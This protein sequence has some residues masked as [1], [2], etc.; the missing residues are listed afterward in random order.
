M[1]ISKHILFL[2][3]GLQLA[4]MPVLVRAQTD[5][6]AGAG[7]V[8][9]GDSTLTDSANHKSLQTLLVDCSINGSPSVTFNTSATYTMS[10]H[11]LGGPVD[12]WGVSC[13]TVQSSSFTT[14]VVLFNS[15]GCSSAT[16]TAYSSGTAVATKTITITAPALGGGSINTPTPATVNYN[17]SPSQ[18]TTTGASGG[19]CSSYSYQ[20]QSSIVSS[21][22]GFSNVSGATSQDFQ[23]GPIT[24]TTWYRRQVSCGIQTA[25][26]SNVVE[27]DVY[28]AISG[29]SVT[30][31]QNINYGATPGVLSVTGYSGGDGSYSYQWQSATDAGF[32]SPTNVGTNSTSYQPPALTSSLYYRVVVTSNGAFAGSSAAFV[33]VYPLLIAGSISP[34]SQTINYNTAPATMTATAASGG[35]GTYTYQ[36]YYWPEGGSAWVLITGATSLSYSPGALTQTTS[37]L[38]QAWSNGAWANSDEVTV[39][40]YPQIVPGSISPSS[41]NANYNWTP[42]GLSISSASGGDGSY[43]YQWQSSADNSF[44][45]PSNVG[46]NS[47]SY[48]PAALTASAYYRVKVTSNGAI[49]PSASAFINVY[50]VVNPGTVSPASQSISYNTAPSVLSVTGVSGGDGSYSYQWQSSPDNSFG[51]PTNVGTNATSYQP[52][53]LTAFVYYRCLVTSNGAQATSVSGEVSIAL[54]GGTISGPSTILPYNGST[55]LNNV[56]GAEGGNCGGSY[57]YQWLQSQDGVHF[58]SISGATGLSYTTD[59]LTVSTVFLRQVVC[60]SDWINSNTILVTVSP[61]LNYIRTRDLTRPGIIDPAS[62]ASLTDPSDVKQVT[63]YFDGLGR[64]VQAVAKQ[65]SPGLKDMVTL[66]VYDALGREP[67]KYLPYVSS[68][69]DGNFR[70]DGIAEAAAFNSV[71]F[72]NEHVFYGQTNFEPSPLNRPVTTLAPGDSWVGAGRGVTLDYLVNTIADS[73]HY[74]TIAAAAGSLPSDAGLYAAGVLYKNQT[75]DEQGHR[76]VEYKDQ[77]GKVILKK[78]QADDTPGTAH[79]GWLCTYYVYD[80]MDNL[81]FVLPPKAIELVNG[82]GTWTVGQTIADELCFRYEYDYRKRMSIKKVPGAGE[83]HMVYDGRDRLVLTQDSALRSQQKWT[84]IRYDGQNRPDSTGLLTDPSNYNNQEHH[85]NLAGSSSSYPNVSS[86][87]NELLTRTFYD[88]YTWTP[89]VWS[90][91]TATMYSGNS[92]LFMTASN[93]TFPYPQPVTQSFNTR[94]MVTGGTKEIVGQP[95]SYLSSVNYFD[96]R[97]RLLQNISVNLTGCGEPATMQYSF[98]GQPLVKD[99]LAQN[100]SLA[101]NYHVLS[102]YNYDAGGRLLDIKKTILGGDGTVKKAQ[103]T[104]VSNTYNELGQLQKKNLGGLDSMVYDYNIRGWL[105]GINKN[106][107]GGTE[108]HYFGMDLGYDKSTSIAGTTSY[109]TPAFNGNISGTVWKSAGDGINRKYDFTYDNVNRLTGA[110]FLQNPSG[111]TWNTTAMDYSVSNLHYDANGN[112]LSMNQNGFKIGAPA[113][114]IDQLTYSYQTSSN[115][116]IQVND[117]VNDTASKLGDFHYKGSKGS[118]DYSYDGNGNLTLDNNKGI[119]QISYNYLN[120]PQ[121]VH[122]NGKGNIIYTYDAAGNKL[123]KVVMDSVSGLA[124]TTEYLGAFQYQR[125]A[126]I[127]SPTAGT[128]TLQFMEEEEGRARWAFHRYLNGTTGYGWEY[129]FT[130]K[131]HLGNT[132]VLLTQEKDTAQ[133]V[134]TMEAAYRSTELALF[135]NIDSTSY[136]AASVPGGYPSDPMTSPNDSV[137]RVNGNGH[138]MGPA[139]LLKVMSGDSAAIGVKSFYRS[140][141]SVGS[142][143][144]SLQ[145]V[146]SSLATGLVGVTGGTHG[147]LSDLNNTSGSP[148][149]AAL[150]SF[151]P[152]NDPATSTTPKAYLN[153]MLLDNQFNYVSGNNQSGAI[154]VGSAD[155]LNTLATG[156]GLHHSGYLYIWVSNETPGWDVFFDNLSVQT[157]SGPML[158]ENHYYP[159]GLTMAGISDKAL[160]GNYTENKFRYNGKE[161]Q[162][163]EFADGSGLEEYDYGAR[164]L[165]PQLGVWHGIDPLAD[166]SRRWS[167]YNYA[168]NNPI[169]FIDPDGMDAGQYGCE[170]WASSDYDPGNEMVKYA[171]GVDGAGNVHTIVYDKGD[172]DDEEYFNFSDGNGSGGEGPGPKKSSGGTNSSQSSLS[173]ISPPNVKDNVALPEALKRIKE[174]MERMEALGTAND[175]AGKFAAIGGYDKAS[176]FIEKAGNGFSIIAAVNHLLDK[177]YF[178][179]ALDIASLTKAS[180][181]VFAF[182]TAKGVLTS[183]FTLNQGA[184]D[185]NQT[186]LRLV[187]EARAEREAGHDAAA[188]KLFQEAGMYADIRDRL[189]TEKISGR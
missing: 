134:A 56:Q 156:I 104:L 187:N 184:Y 186:C 8:I 7:S 129:D 67:L 78:V 88:D 159:F 102:N 130:E 100:C 90:F 85:E 95:G 75:T 162:N 121:Q 122:I 108:S 44:G 178:D 99:Y 173:Q 76:L 35:T 165:D 124:T 140:G 19:L 135:Y 133:Y 142:P 169:R 123:R 58:T 62:A 48:Q 176:E 2:L 143:N 118:Y 77:Q 20:W 52:P 145:S 40:V 167:P 153:W 51:S 72:A 185:A 119:D 115:K 149:Y 47:T 112:I 55:V 18:L 70:P 38:I 189:I 120:L 93:L 117:A 80:D 136:P 171:V 86:Y 57:S 1:K 4:L 73:V 125:R 152:A 164:F 163:Q 30:P 13:G 92:G 161:L 10:G 49:V 34:S 127:A 61:D 172:N 16:V 111:S 139:L 21:T 131:D 146:L 64:P 94:G 54:N 28:P 71:Q 148:V 183:D 36:W 25:F 9:A 59:N 170:A 81:R 137:A 63:Q 166:N 175:W 150:N 87:T 83:V 33:N 26:T 6:T 24:T 106:Y 114:L 32:S 157:Y 27:V 22:S 155:V 110:T 3:A 160:K 101:D 141:G 74:W 23:P 179:A 79:A 41:Q 50:P 103:T 66:N 31:G 105:T 14:F 151:L 126:P 132:R 113:S 60:G 174:G 53:A 147:V 69:T 11:C 46:T 84:Y 154:P 96:D 82:S 65:A 39:T 168:F 37:Y 116:L 17:A 43:S 181:W 180:P 29:G 144:N 91:F 177:K 138:K 107:V 5:S 109:T 15:A 97:G 128:D 158:E 188:N 45:S 98:S 89:A 12:S 68:N 42:A 182:N